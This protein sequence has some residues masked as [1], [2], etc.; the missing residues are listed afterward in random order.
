MASSLVLM[1][2]VSLSLLFSSFRTVCAATPPGVSTR[3]FSTTAASGYDSD[4]YDSDDDRRTDPRALFPFYSS[5]FLLL[6]LSRMYG[7]TKTSHSTRQVP[8]FE[9][10]ADEYCETANRSMK[11]KCTGEA[12]HLRLLMPGVAKADAKVYVDENQRLI[13][14]GKKEK[15]FEV[16]KEDFLPRFVLHLPMAFVK[17]NAITAEM[18]NGV[19]KLYIPTTKQLQERSDNVLFV[20]VH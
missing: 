8:F 3:F 2:L 16:G 10:A 9:Q 19:L 15:D 6:H 1:Y 14:E 5:L 20:S 11:Y 17:A 7:A 12:L 13:V 4:D 18:K